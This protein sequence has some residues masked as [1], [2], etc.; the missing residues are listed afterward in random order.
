MIKIW[1][2]KIGIKLK[3]KGYVWQKEKSVYEI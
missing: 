3:V 2:F 1:N